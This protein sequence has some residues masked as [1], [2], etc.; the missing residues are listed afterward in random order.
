MLAKLGHKVMS[1]NRVAIGPI[2]LKGLIGGEHRSL[3]RHE[4]ELL[5]KV[6]HGATLSLPGFPDGDTPAQARRSTSR[7]REANHGQRGGDRAGQTRNRNRDSARDLGS[8]RSPNQSRLIIQPSGYQAQ[9]VQPHDAGASA[10]RTAASQQATRR[11]SAGDRQA[12]PPTRTSL[13]EAKT[14]RAHPQS[15]RS[16]SPAKRRIIGGGFEPA[17]AP[18]AQ[19][20]TD[21]GHKRPL[22]RKR[23]PSATSPIKRRHATTGP[24]GTDHDKA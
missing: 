18:G 3:S 11:G 8:I 5:W 24:P 19:A 13:P 14:H 7:H 17:T 20:K 23:R 15:A 12:N 4:V 16:I 1:L 9:L 10:P 2:S 22:R 21:R 6:A